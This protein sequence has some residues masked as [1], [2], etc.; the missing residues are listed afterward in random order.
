MVKCDGKISIKSYAYFADN[1]V[2]NL[3]SN[4]V[5]SNH[6]ENCWDEDGNALEI[7]IKKSI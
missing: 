5:G 2:L 3:L 7:G 4:K 6:F 1:C